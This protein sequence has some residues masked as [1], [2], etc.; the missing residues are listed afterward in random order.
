MKEQDT[1]KTYKVESVLP[2]NAEDTKKVQITKMF[3]A[4]SDQYDLMNRAMTMGV[5]I[6][7]RRNAI[8][9]L[10]PFAPKLILDVAT[11]TG[12]FAVEA[13]KRLHADKVIG[14]DLSANM[15]EIGKIKVAKMGLSSKI[16]LNLG[17]CMKLDFDSNL[18]DAVTVAFG[19]R[20]YESLEQGISEMCR[21]LKPG[22]NL[23]ILEMSEPFT[24]AKPFY[25]IYT[26]FV[27]PAIAR[28]Y[29]KD[30]SAYHYLPNS[31]EAFPQG[32][33]MIALLKKCGFTEV[34]HRR[35]TFGVCAFYRARK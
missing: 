6:A 20:N 32:K 19:V 16:E 21:V 17:D 14:V 1:H 5:D 8:H 7:W 22:G 4:I 31:I 10:K 23:V 11:G 13:Y 29:S 27:I 12:D 33:E 26:K 34:K 24:W 2:Y 30:K 35:F 3:D 18:F 15:L 25:K 28:I 9:S